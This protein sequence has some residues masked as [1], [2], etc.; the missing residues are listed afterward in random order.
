MVGVSFIVD[1]VI[2]DISFSINLMCVFF[3]N[4]MLVGV[5]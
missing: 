1:I 3:E 5:F 4:I 2:D